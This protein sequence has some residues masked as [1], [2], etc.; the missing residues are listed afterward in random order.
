MGIEEFTQE[1]ED[2]K[3][4]ELL[5]MNFPR[6]K[7]SILL[8][9]AVDVKTVGMLLTVAL[10]LLVKKKKKKTPP[11][12]PRGTIALQTMATFFFYGD[13]R[14]KNSSTSYPKLRFLD[15]APKM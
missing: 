11:P 3:A 15:Q 4:L 7:V 6:T 14:K 12:S 2:R 10:K 9:S 5:C 1:F 13:V 8:W